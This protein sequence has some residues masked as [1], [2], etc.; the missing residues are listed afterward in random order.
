MRKLAIRC[1]ILGIV[2]LI[3][4]RLIRSG[5]P[6]GPVRP[7][8]PKNQVALGVTLRAIPSAAGRSDYQAYVLDVDLRAA[9]GRVVAENPGLNRGVVYAEARSVADW[10][11]RYR[12]VGGINGGFFGLTDR[13]RKE[14]VGLLATGGVVRASGR[15][16]RSTR[17]P[18]QR[19]A[20]CVLGFDAAGIP[21]IAWATG[22]RGNTA[23]LANYTQ[24]VNADRPRVWPVDSAVA[25]G[26]SLIHNARIRVTDREER[27]VSRGRLRR[28]FAGYSLQNG[29]PRHLVLAVAPAMTF[30]DAADFLQAY[31]RKYHQSPCAE[32]MCLDGGASSQLAYRSGSGYADTLLTPVTVPTAVVV[33]SR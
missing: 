10:C 14:I 11:R 3:G 22:E 27:L 33:T 26:P 4:V 1:L 21:Q 16:I 23:R 32:A 25:C 28:T 19:F 9:R 5:P 29:R 8:P 13:N 7:D 18:G 15:L 20:H 17:N 24:P 30:S 2:V 6:P 31:F 12:A